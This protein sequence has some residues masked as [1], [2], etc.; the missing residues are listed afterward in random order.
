MLFGG[1][2]RCVFGFFSLFCSSRQHFVP[3][4]LTRLTLVDYLVVLVTDGLMPQGARVT[5]KT[6]SCATGRARAVFGGRLTKLEKAF[7]RDKYYEYLVHVPVVIR[8][9]QRAERRRGLQAER[10]A[11]DQRARGRHDSAP[12]GTHRGAGGAARAA[13]GGGLPRRPRGAHPPALG[14]DVLPGPR[15][16]AEH[17]LPDGG[18]DAAAH[19]GANFQLPC[20]EDV[21]ASAFVDKPLCVPGSC[22][23]AAA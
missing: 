17:A 22:G 8:G 4:G 18:G 20:E 7:F 11:A 6:F 21:L 14:Q 9:R 12:R 15:G 10:L 1:L 5:K 2:L 3:L 19:A 23:A 16:H 13:G